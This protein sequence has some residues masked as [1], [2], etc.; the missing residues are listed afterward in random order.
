[1]CSA[2][3][4]LSATSL[5]EI[6]PLSRAK[7]SALSGLYIGRY[8]PQPQSHIKGIDAQRGPE[9]K[10]ANPMLF[11]VAGGAQRNGAAIARLHPYAAIGSCTHMRGVR[12]C[13]FAASDGGKLTDKSEM[14]YSP[15]QI[16]LGLAVRYRPALRTAARSGSA[17]RFLVFVRGNENSASL[18]RSRG[19]Q[20]RVRFE[21]GSAVPSVV[22]QL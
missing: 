13:C 21:R 17:R 10:L 3:K 22:T 5:P 2:A 4:R 6:D 12:W 18:S 11:R 14:L 20:T 7:D 9:G 15:T 1:L 16:W 8:R 19:L